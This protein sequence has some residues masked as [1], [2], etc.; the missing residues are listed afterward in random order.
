MQ[1]L[2]A[3]TVDTETTPLPSGRVE[4]RRGVVD[5]V[6][7][8]GV[9]PAGQGLTR[10]ELDR[11]LLSTYARDRLAG[12][13]A[14]AALILV[15]A[16]LASAWLPSASVVVWSLV[17]LCSH[18]LLGVVCFSFRKPDAVGS[19]FR[20]GLFSFAELLCGLGWV[21]LLVLLSAE[22]G[23]EAAVFQFAILLAVA[24]AATAL[25]AAL[26]VAMIAA[27]APA[28]LTLVALFAF[29][30]EPLLVA[31]AWLSG[32]TAI[33]FIWLSL[34][35]RRAIRDG[36]LARAERARLYQELLAT[37]EQAEHALQRA[38]K[39]SLARSRFLA[40]M[41]HELRTPLNAILG[42]SE[43]M[44]NEVLG[45]MQNG[46]YREYAGDIHASGGHL[47]SL[48]NEILDLSRLE[49]GRYELNEVPVALEAIVRACESMV[50]G[51]ARS[52]DL[53]LVLEIE[54]DL[55]LVRADPAGLRRAVLNLLSNAV[56]F[57]P[58]GG[59]ITLQAGWTAG[60][61]QYVSVRDTGPG[62]P[63]GEVALVLSPF[64]QGESAMH[65]A[66]PGAGMGLPMVEALIR[67]HGGTFE[68]RSTMGA[69]TV[70]TLCLPRSRVLEAP[71]EDVPA[72]EN[73]IL[74]RSAG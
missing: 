50:A 45:P 52:R 11:A 7:E 64:Q 74:W 49:T 1:G 41:N 47:L 21:G 9:A 57:T 34:R 55:P 17:A 48:I 25:A 61:G 59:T 72:R 23:P 19:P 42:F 26:P 30:E 73:V 3:A 33:F 2:T 68:L 65:M 69:G 27:T 67:L 53:R 40:T 10:A 66:K 54:P 37:R 63:A 39:A 16:G 8:P 56:K 36:I 13:P 28:A 38:D 4:R 24:C 20:G 22:H 60:G 15:A 12:S 70:A 31:L 32:A 43:V 6:R 44:K 14:M 62:I 51:E 58:A 46:T 18:A 71:S 29:R 35:E 5:G